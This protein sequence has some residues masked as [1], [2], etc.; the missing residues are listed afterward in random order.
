MKNKI[1]MEMVDKKLLNM[2]SI[3][4]GKSTCLSVALS[5]FIIFSIQSVPNVE[6]ST[7]ISFMAGI[8]YFLALISCLILVFSTVFTHISGWNLKH[9]EQVVSI[10][11]V[12]NFIP[13][14][15]AFILY[16]ACFTTMFNALIPNNQL[17]GFVIFSL[18]AFLVTAIVTSVAKSR[19]KYLAGNAGIPQQNI[20]PHQPKKL[21]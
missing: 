13:L 9:K 21:F 4:I 14:F 7:D 2:D 11:W 19:S 8:G 5:V 17:S 3:N 12:I 16:T 1:T 15:F 18:F 6:D 20:Q 10:W